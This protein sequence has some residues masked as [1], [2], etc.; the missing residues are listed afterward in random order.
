MTWYIGIC[1]QCGI[2]F[3]LAP[4]TI[5]SSEVYPSL[6]LS[7]NPSGY[8]FQKWV[9]PPG[10]ASNY[11][12]MESCII[13][14]SRILFVLWHLAEWFQIGREGKGVHMLCGSGLDTVVL[15]TVSF[16]P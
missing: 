11:T 13:I 14:R 8:L 12:P 1:T 5:A 7:D 3:S 6:T 4:G 15:R 10:I 2:N 16:Q 9:W